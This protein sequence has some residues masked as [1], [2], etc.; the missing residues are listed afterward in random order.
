MKTANDFKPYQA[1]RI[2]S[3]DPRLRLHGQIGFVTPEI[4][5]ICGATK[6]GHVLVTFDYPQLGFPSCGVLPEHLEDAGTFEDFARAWLSNA[7][8]TRH[9]SP[10]TLLKVANAVWNEQDRH[11]FGDGPD[12]KSSI[13]LDR[14]T[15]DY[16]YDF[17]APWKEPKCYK[18]YPGQYLAI[19]GQVDRP[20]ARLLVLVTPRQPNEA[21]IDDGCAR[22]LYLDKSI[23]GQWEKPFTVMESSLTPLWEFGVAAIVRDAH[24]GQIEIVKRAE[25]AA[26]YKDGKPRPWQEDRDG[27]CNVRRDARTVILELLSRPVPV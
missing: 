22:A 25:S 8:A 12:W 27:L 19:N 5:G 24:S 13:L 3:E 11:D 23:A 1:V 21:D 9:A 17:K 18:S 4:G 2:S 15:E 26:K 16:G 20:C 7:I 14:L 6:E 10:I